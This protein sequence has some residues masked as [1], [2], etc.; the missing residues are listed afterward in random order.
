MNKLAN[1]APTNWNIISFNQLSG[2][3]A[4][5]TTLQE[6]ST[7]RIKTQEQSKRANVLVLP[8]KS[9]INI[10]NN[11]PALPAD[12]MRSED[13]LPSMRKVIT[14]YESQRKILEP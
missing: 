1:N 10:S 12:A 9:K 11:T 5:D 4:S 2:K 3:I 7:S 14:S 13:K 8:S 6:G